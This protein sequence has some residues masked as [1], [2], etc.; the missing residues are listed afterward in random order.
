MIRLA[1]GVVLGVSFFVVGLVIFG[2]SVDVFDRK[3]VTDDFWAALIIGVT[4]ILLGFFIVRIS[5]K[6]RRRRQA[7][8]MGHKRATHDT[9]EAEGVMMGLGM[10]HLMNS[11]DTDNS[12]DDGGDFGD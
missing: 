4:L 12:G 2:A 1:I 9:G 8:A 7:I 6:A 10:A 11:D 3:G 5:F